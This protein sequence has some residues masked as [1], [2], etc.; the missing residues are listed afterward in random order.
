M[1]REKKNKH[2][3]IDFDKTVLHTDI[4]MLLNQDQVAEKISTFFYRKKIKLNNRF[5]GPTSFEDLRTVN[6]IIVQTYQGACKRLG[7]LK[8]DQYW[9]NTLA[10][11]V[12]GIASYI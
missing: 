1:H 3:G 4:S 10:N 12:A 2:V 5:R 11:E 6:G 7:L 9:E 8:G